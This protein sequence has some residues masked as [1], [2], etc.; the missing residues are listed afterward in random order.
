MVEEIMMKR[1]KS[2]AKKTPEEVRVHAIVDLIHQ[3]VVEPAELEP[4][5][6]LEPA[7]A[8]EPEPESTGE[9]LSGVSELA[10]ALETATAECARLSKK[11]TTLA[12]EL[13]EAKA[14]M[15]VAGEE[16]QMLRERVLGAEQDI[17]SYQRDI[18]V[19]QGAHERDRAEAR[20]SEVDRDAAEA[21][22]RD[23]EGVL[24]RI[25]SFVSSALPKEDH[26]TDEESES[27]AIILSAALE[28]GWKNED[29][30]FHD[31]N[32]QRP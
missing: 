17:T 12:A 32:G 3:Q 24:K 10:K 15:I 26:A 20:A 19:Y 14:Q 25:D 29:P 13:E 1:K 11:S 31:T 8:P 23:L 2:V 9:W 6:K 4:E 30:E 18:A 7:P 22:V 28:S 21:R 27:G 16:M 5:P